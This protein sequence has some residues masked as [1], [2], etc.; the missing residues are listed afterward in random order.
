MP[1]DPII[2]RYNKA[3]SGYPG[4]IHPS[5]VYSDGSHPRSIHPKA[6]YPS[7]HLIPTGLPSLC[8]SNG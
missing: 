2:S 4:A 7:E 8:Q 5:A 6:S 3:A 1:Q